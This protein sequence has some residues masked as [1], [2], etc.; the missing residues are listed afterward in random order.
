MQRR[1]MRLILVLRARCLYEASIR[2]RDIRR[3]TA[4]DEACLGVGKHIASAAV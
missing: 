2:R 1:S 3:K 4:R